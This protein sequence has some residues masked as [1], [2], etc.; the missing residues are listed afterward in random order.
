[1]DAGGWIA[2]FPGAITV[3]DR[4]GTILS[5]NRRAVATFREQGGEALIGTNLLDCHPEPSR[6]KLQDLL[7]R[8]RANIYTIEKQGR[9][10]LVYQTP[11]YAAGSPAG[12]VELVLEL[13][14]EMPHFLRRG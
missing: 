4:R 9:R 11:W 1:M 2:E 5:M 8:P 12:L 13:P 7:E 3:C 6:S 14:A 10:K